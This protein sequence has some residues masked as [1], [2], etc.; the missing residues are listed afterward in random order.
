MPALHPAPRP[1]RWQRQPDRRPQQILD[2]AFQ[3]FGSRGLHQAT[4]EEVA[5]Q[6]GISKGTIYLYFPGKAALFTAMLKARVNDFMPA[7]EAPRDTGV[8]PIRDRLATLGRHL[9]RFFR[10]PAY[11]AIYRTM[12]SEALDFPEAAALLYREGILP[13]NRRLAEVIRRGILAGECRPVDPLVAARAFAG[14]FQVFAVSQELLGGKHIY[15]LAESK[16]IRTLTDIFLHGVRPQ[17][18]GRPRVPRGAR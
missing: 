13:A 6:A 1:R 17:A 9:Y 15:P 4:L 12:V 7:V 18:H 5:R 3:V 16:V 8:V 14:M 11:L 10:S 2:A